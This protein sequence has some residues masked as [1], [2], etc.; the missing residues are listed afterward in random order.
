MRRRARRPRWR[1]RRRW[2][3]SYRGVGLQLLGLGVVR[4]CP[5]AFG[6]CLR[7]GGRGVGVGRGLRR[8]VRLGARPSGRR[9]GVV[10]L[11]VGLVGCCPCVVG[12]AGPLEGRR[13][14]G[15]RVGL[16]PGGV[17]LLLG[18]PGV[19]PHVLRARSRAGL[20]VLLPGHGRLL[21]RLGARLRL[22]GLRG[23]GLG[24]LPVPGRF[25]LLGVGG[26]LLLL[27]RR[28]FGLRLQPLGVCAAAAAF[29]LDSSVR[30]TASLASAVSLSLARCPGAAWPR[31]WRPWPEAPPFPR[32]SYGT[33]PST[34]RPGPG[35]AARSSRCPRR[36]RAWLPPRS[37]R[38]SPVRR[39]RRQHLA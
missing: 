6:R 19:V 30:A 10:R 20:R 11:P 18:V 38:P 39:A 29:A 33:R 32:P 8:G 22:L 3:R 4:V 24:G 15:L 25:G 23:L 5:G 12:G 27:R 34:A 7:L 1:R 13:V 17:R 36:R 2:S 31:P 37:H 26:R 14:G 21:G 28:L 16:R 35:R 9:L